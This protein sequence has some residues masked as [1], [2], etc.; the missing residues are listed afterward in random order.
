MF[1]CIVRRHVHL[2]VEYIV[3]GYVHLYVECIVQGHVHLY[4]EHIVQG[5]IIYR[6]NALFGDMFICR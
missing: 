1:I 5:I 2:R 4:V 6:C 3:Q